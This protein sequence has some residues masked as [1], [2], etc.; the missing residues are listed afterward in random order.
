VYLWSF[1]YWSVFI[2]NW[3]VLPFLQ[4]YLAAGDF[5]RRERL[6]RSLRNNIPLLLIFFLAF[7]IIL[8]CL[9]FTENGRKAL[10]K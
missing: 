7:I 9:A 10:A 1:N 8:I 4:E 5:T 3:L 6:M 2:L